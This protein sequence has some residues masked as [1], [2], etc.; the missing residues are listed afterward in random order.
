MCLLKC[1]SLGTDLHPQVPGMVTS[2]SQKAGHHSRGGGDGSKTMMGLCETEEVMMVA[3][4][5]VLLTPLV[6]SCTLG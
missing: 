3:V 5:V 4:A 6:V 2:D 1:G